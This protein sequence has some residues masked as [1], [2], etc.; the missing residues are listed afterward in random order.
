MDEAQFLS[1]KQV[2]ELWFIAKEKTFLLF[3]LDLKLILNQ[4][5][6]MVQKGYLS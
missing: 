5:F 6:L 3:V 4:N 1:K 2:E